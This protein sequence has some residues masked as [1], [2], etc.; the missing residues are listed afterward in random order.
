MRMCAGRQAEGVTGVRRPRDQPFPAF[1][2]CA[3]FIRIPNRADH[4]RAAVKGIVVQYD[5]R[6]LPGSIP[7]GAQV[8]SS[9][10]ELLGIAADMLV[11]RE[12]PRIDLNCGCP[13][14]TVTGSGAGSRQVR[15]RQCSSCCVGG[16]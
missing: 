6:E 2:A 12:A 11:D 8:M 10:A 1:F 5:A 3:E 14:N 7:L 9:S 4:P 13:A 16:G 15:S